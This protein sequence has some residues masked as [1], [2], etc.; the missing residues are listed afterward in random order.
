MKI[1]LTEIFVVK[2]TQTVVFLHYI[3]TNTWTHSKLFKLPQKYRSE[4][5]YD[6]SLC[7]VSSLDSLI[8]VT[9]HQVCLDLDFQH[10]RNFQKFEPVTK[11]FDPKWKIFDP[12]STSIHTFFAKD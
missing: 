1:F 5:Y 7:Y 4:E 3:N 12:M 9:S 8:F 11:N 6:G 10:I 2:F